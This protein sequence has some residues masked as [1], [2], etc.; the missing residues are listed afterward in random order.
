MS[1]FDFDRGVCDS[2]RTG[3]LG[4]GRR[5]VDIAQ[6]GDVY[7]FF[8]SQFRGEKRKLLLEDCRDSRERVERG[9]GEKA[10][11]KLVGFGQGQAE[12][13]MMKELA[14]KVVICT[15]QRTPRA[16]NNT[17]DTGE[18]SGPPFSACGTNGRCCANGKNKSKTR[19]GRRRA[20]HPPAI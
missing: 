19:R 17:V 16:T 18:E 1:A 9:G 4:T 3:G 15:L 5:H 20:H 11:V 14:L 12:F 7:V 8:Q 6:S 10:K 2:R 13:H